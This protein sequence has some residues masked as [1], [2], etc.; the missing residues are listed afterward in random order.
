MEARDL[1]PNVSQRAEPILGH[2]F[3]IIDEAYQF[4]NT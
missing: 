2:I 4:Y 1:E 3:S